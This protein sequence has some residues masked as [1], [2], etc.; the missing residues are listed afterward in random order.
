MILPNIFVTIVII[1]LFCPK[2]NFGLFKS[3][4]ERRKVATEKGTMEMQ[5]S[6]MMKKLAQSPCRDQVKTHD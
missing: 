6:R 5:K 1:L 3:S 2:V 4:K